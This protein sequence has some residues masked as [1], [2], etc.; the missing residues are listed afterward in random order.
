MPGHTV[1]RYLPRQ[2]ISLIEGKGASLYIFFLVR[3]S[4]C[5]R[6]AIHTYKLGRLISGA[7]YQTRVSQRSSLMRRKP[8][9][10]ADIDLFRADHCHQFWY[11]IQ[12]VACNVSKPQPSFFC[13]VSLPFGGRFTT[14]ELRALSFPFPLQGELGMTFLVEPHFGVLTCAV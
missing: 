9:T 14:G 2:R 6:R 3:L 13:F 5:L 10:C 11:V 12:C 7:I 4:N 8:C 1:S